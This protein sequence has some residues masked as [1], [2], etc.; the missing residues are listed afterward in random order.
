[1]NIAT[2]KNITIIIAIILIII[3]I[4]FVMALN[5]PNTRSILIKID[6]NTQEE[7]LYKGSTSPQYIHFYSLRDLPDNTNLKIL[8]ITTHATPQNMFSVMN[9]T[10]EQTII[11]WLNNNGIQNYPDYEIGR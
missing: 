6:N 8:T 2:I 3:F 10:Y 7:I 4:S 5:I 1:M 11:D 9:T